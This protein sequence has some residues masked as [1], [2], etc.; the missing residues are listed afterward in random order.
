MKL[1]AALDVILERVVEYL[2]HYSGKGNDPEEIELLI[3]IDES[4][5]REAIKALRELGYED[6]ADAV[7]KA[8][9]L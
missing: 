9:D 5:Q 3:G 4:E 7:E 1:G 6:T 2:D 8:L